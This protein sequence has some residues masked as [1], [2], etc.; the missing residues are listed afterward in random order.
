MALK[1]DY[2]TIGSRIKRRRKQ[3]KKTQEDL[4]EHLS[5]SV[6]YISQV[7]RGVT[8]ISLD[9]LSEISVWMDCDLAELVT[10]TS[11]NQKN[12]LD[13]EF[14]EVYR[15]LRSDQKKMLIEIALVMLDY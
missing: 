10:G 6:G 9:T 1:I 15:R 12:Y 2:A 13:R 8:K 3:I 14:S 7:E 4:A 5:V 11:P